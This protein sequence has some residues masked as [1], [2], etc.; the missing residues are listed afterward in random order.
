MTSSPGSP[1]SPV[2]PR[3]GSRSL[4]LREAGRR[5]TVEVLG[6]SRKPR[7]LSPSAKPRGVTR[8]ASKKNGTVA[9]AEFLEGEGKSLS[10][11]AKED[12]AEILASQAAA[13]EVA[14]SAAA[15]AAAS[16][17]NA[18]ALAFAQKYRLDVFETKTVLTEFRHLKLNPDGSASFPDFYKFMCRVFDTKQP[19]KDLLEKIYHET[20]MDSAARVEK[21][22]E[23]Y[24][25]NVF[26]RDL[27]GLMHAASPEK[28]Q[29]EIAVQKL[30]RDLN[31][32]SS[33]IDNIKR[34][35]DKYD[36]DNSGAIDYKEFGSM[37]KAMLKAKDSCDLSESRIRKFWMEIDHDGS[38]EVDFSE[39]THWYLKYFS[40]E[41]TAECGSCNLIEAFYASFNPSN[42]RRWQTDRM[43][44]APPN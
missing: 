43:N 12:T 36:K 19:S 44:S 21:F 23:W 14:A 1:G 10:D 11:A 25:M 27:L 40:P 9:V 34:E 18:Q 6:R 32:A 15:S 35:F 26:S 2:G 16:K 37:L 29:A 5:A 31:V 24:M 28:L 39:F 42:Q 7:S 30:A 8:T 13:A 17:L 38:G 3:P 22:L 33:Q 20:G 41:S 4:L